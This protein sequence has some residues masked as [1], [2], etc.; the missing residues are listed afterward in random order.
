[1]LSLS[2]CPVGF[3]VVCGAVG[4][5]GSEATFSGEVTRVTGAPASGESLQN[6]LGDDDEPEVDEEVS[7]EFS[8]L[9]RTINT[10]LLI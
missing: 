8:L 4:A 10:Y 7:G 6:L 9:G 3:S 1:M 5:Q 2:L